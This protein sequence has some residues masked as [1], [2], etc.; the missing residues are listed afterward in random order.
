M[1]LAR[2]LH[3]L[4]L[5]F[6]LLTVYNVKV[7]H[8]HCILSL[9]VDLLHTHTTEAYSMWPNIDCSSVNVIR[10]QYCWLSTIF[11]L[12]VS[13]RAPG[14]QYPAWITCTN[15]GALYYGILIWW[16]VY[17]FQ[18]TPQLLH[19]AP[20]PLVKCSWRDRWE[21]KTWHWRDHIDILMFFTLIS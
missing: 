18:K 15:A 8:T 21:H 7:Q 2:M 19:V 6:P 20:G 9:H 14:S 11:S 3:K 4:T 16:K 10:L 1:L 13:V 5:L 12:Q 17:S